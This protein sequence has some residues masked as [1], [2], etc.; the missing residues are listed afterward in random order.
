MNKK[1]FLTLPI[2]IFKQVPH[3][4]EKQPSYTPLH[5][6]PLFRL[7]LKKMKN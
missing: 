3:S 1:S 2:E 7:N 6:A 4:T 5:G